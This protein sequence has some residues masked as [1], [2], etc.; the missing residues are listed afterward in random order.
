MA[1]S[2]RGLLGAAVTR[3]RQLLLD[4]DGVAAAAQGIS[5]S[6]QE[7]KALTALA[8]LEA[9]LH[10]AVRQKMDGVRAK[11]KSDMKARIRG[12]M[13]NR[14]QRLSE[15]HMIVS[16]SSAFMRRYWNRRYRSVRAFSSAKHYGCILT[17]CASSST[18][19]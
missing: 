19:S 17:A 9:Q 15:C 18:K 6:Q 14:A 12:L 8:T 13:I 11:L 2:R 7:E 4:L 1:D 10:D 16:L 5:V 3:S